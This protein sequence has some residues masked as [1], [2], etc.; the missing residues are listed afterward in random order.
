MSAPKHKDPSKG[1][2]I[3]FFVCFTS[4]VVAIGV[5][6]CFNYKVDA[7]EAPVAGGH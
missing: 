2:L 5:Y 1:W 3:F 6:N 7:P 4:S